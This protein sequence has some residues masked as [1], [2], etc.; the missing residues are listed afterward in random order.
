MLSRHEERPR[1]EPS[2]ERGRSWERSPHRP[3][4]RADQVPPA[5]DR[6][7]EGAED[8]GAG[9]DGHAGGT[10]RNAWLRESARGTGVEGGSHRHAGVF[11]S[12]EDRGWRRD[13]RGRWRGFEERPRG[14]GGNG[15]GDAREGGSQENA[16]Q[17]VRQERDA[18]ET[19][20]NQGWPVEEADEED[21]NEV[22]SEGT[23]EAKPGPAEEHEGASQAAVEESK[24]TLQESCGRDG[25]RGEGQRAE[26]SR[27]QERGAPDE[28]ARDAQAPRPHGKEGAER[29]RTP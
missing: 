2:R 16:A 21:G 13:E 22:Q 27:R 26:G 11:H 15:S 23:S 1:R 28:G 20:R 3:A 9:V 17:E 8:V 25:S 14:R 6:R 7:G 18:E 24:T 4:F 19:E 5:R 29:S 10:D 12:P